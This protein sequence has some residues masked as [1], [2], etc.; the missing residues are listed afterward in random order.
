MD[1]Y[2][3]CAV[4]KQSVALVLVRLGIRPNCALGCRVS[5]MIGRETGTEVIGMSGIVCKR[6]QLSR[7]GVL[8]YVGSKLFFGRSF[9]EFKPEAGTA[10]SS[11]HVSNVV[12]G[13]IGDPISGGEI[14]S[15]SHHISWLVSASGQY[16]GTFCS[17]AEIV[18][19]FVVPFPSV[20]EDEAVAFVIEGH[21]RIDGDVVGTMNHNTALVGFP[22]NILG[23]G[24]TFYVSGHVEMQ[25]ILSQ[26]SLLSHICQQRPLQVLFDHGRVQHDDVSAESLQIVLDFLLALNYETS[27]QQRHLNGKVGIAKCF[28]DSRLFFFRGERRA[29]GQADLLPCR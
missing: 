3:L 14:I 12:I 26:L 15:F 7:S 13:G 19:E 23:E 6:T 11:R 17:G 8:V 24:G 16:G 27:I 5:R 22:D 4:E 9:F 28:I 25:G 18:D 1:P 29:T 2:V 21:V 10:A 20:L